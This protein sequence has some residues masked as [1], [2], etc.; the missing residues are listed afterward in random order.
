M[1][2]DMILINLQK[3]FDT[4]NHDMLFQTLYAIGFW[5]HTVNWFKPYFSYFWLI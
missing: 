3:A 5:K 4:I 2:F 1:I